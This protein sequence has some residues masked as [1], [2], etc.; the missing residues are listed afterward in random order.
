[1]ILLKKLFTKR[2]IINIIGVILGIG[3]G[4]LYYHF[5]GCTNGCPINSNP[6]L[7]MIWGGLLGYLITS[8]FKDK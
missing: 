8:L 7:S 2:F 1:M 6:F 5:Y 3:G 4:Y